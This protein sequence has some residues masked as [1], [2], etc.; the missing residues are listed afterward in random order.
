M[1]QQMTLFEGV[2]H[3]KRIYMK[4]AGKLCSEG[5]CMNEAFARGM[6]SKHYAYKRRNGWLESRP[7]QAVC[8]RCGISVEVKPLGIL[9]KFCAECRYVYKQ[10][11]IVLR[12]YGLSSEEYDALAELQSGVCGICYGEADNGASRNRGFLSIDHDH[13]T[14]LVRGLLCSNCNLALGLLKERQDTIL[15]AANWIAEGG[16]TGAR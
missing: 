3:P 13:K 1:T 12:K 14:G 2:L 16:T 7:K 10:R 5:D 8:R 4:N 9:P 6:C 11:R 15:R